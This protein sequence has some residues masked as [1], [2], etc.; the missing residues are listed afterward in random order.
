MK[1]VLLAGGVGTRLMPCTRVTNKHLLPV[2]DRPMVYYP[3][4]TLVGAGIAE[5]M[6]ITGR[7]HMGAVMETLGSGREFGAEFTYRIQD[8]AG[9]IAEALLLARAFV[10]T[11]NVAVI[12]GDNIFEDTFAEDARAFEFDGAAG[13]AK[14]FL[15]KVPDPSRFGVATVH[16]DQVVGIKE[17]PALPESDLAITGLYFYDCGVF[18]TLSSQTYSERGELEISDTNNDYLARGLLTYRILDGFWSDAGTWP[19]LMRAA[20]HCQGG[21][22]GDGE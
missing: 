3:V 8:Q 13:Q 6:V 21:N 2:Y 14:V 17:K 1:G 20:R 19:S 5:I 22:H 12:L 11:D 15:K 7:E 16:G 10:D 9:G 18:D 4:S